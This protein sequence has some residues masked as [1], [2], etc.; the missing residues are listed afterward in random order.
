MLNQPSLAILIDFWNPVLSKE[1][2]DDTIAFLNIDVIKTVVLSTYNSRSELFAYNNSLWYRNRKEW[3]EKSNVSLRDRA[4]LED[5]E[6]IQK[7]FIKNSVTDPL[8]LKYHN[9]NQHQIAMFQYWEIEY[10]LSIHT[11]IKNIYVLGSAWEECV[12]Y[13]PVGY[14][15]L[16]H[17]QRQ[18]VNILTHTNLVRTNKGTCPDLSLDRHWIKVQGNIYRYLGNKKV[19]P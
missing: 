12:K 10:Y 9:S 11:E 16:S 7:H 3:Y 17:L 1:R 18:N 8:I 6:T 15:E 13:R 2:V 14:L 19:D 4:L 5:K